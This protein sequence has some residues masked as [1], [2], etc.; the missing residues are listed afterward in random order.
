MTLTNKKRG[1]RICLD[2]VYYYDDFYSDPMNGQIE[3]DCNLCSHGARVLRC[4]LL[5]FHRQEDAMWIAYEEINRF[6]RRIEQD[7]FFL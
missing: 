3:Q 4:K 2:L 5:S 1:E 7:P 6:Q